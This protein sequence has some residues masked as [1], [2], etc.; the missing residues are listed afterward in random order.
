MYYK[1]NLEWLWLSFQVTVIDNLG[2]ENISKISKEA[3]IAKANAEK[4]IAIAR[5]NANKEQGKVPVFYWYKKLF[6]F[7]L[8]YYY[9]YDKIKQKERKQQNEYC[10]IKRN[11]WKLLLWK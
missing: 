5:A 8:L 7:L 9:Y 1:N 10:K 11:F 2:I 3:S 6:N 4:E